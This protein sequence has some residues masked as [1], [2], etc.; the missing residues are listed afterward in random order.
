MAFADGLRRENVV[1]AH[2]ILST[3]VKLSY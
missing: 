3:V 1:L 2:G